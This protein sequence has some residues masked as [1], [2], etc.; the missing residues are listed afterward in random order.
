MTRLP[1]FPLH[2]VLFPGGLLP[3]KVFEPRYL[4]L[5]AHCLR[6]DSGFGVCLIRAGREVNDAPLVEGLGTLVH[7]DDWAQRPDGLL[8]ITVRGDRRIRIHRTEQDRSGLLVG[9]VEI[10]PREVPQALPP[11]CLD[12]AE[13]LERLVG[14]L[15][16]PLDRLAIHY[17]LAN[18]VANR[19]IELLPLPLE[20][21]QALLAEDDAGRRLER[22]RQGMRALR[23]AS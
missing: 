20:E 17:S 8:G 13:L 4:E 9:E 21:K 2:A 16:P 10:L 11:S 15:G 23:L 18:D 7:I 3:L 19:L 14:E 6:E 1:L 12:L 22:L 5:V